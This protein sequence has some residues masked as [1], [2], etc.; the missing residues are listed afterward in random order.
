MDLFI[1]DNLLF[2]DDDI[3]LYEYINYE[4]R[5]YIVRSR[6]DYLKWD[7]CYFKVRF[8]LSEETVLEVLNL[9]QPSISSNSR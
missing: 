9:I 6:I 2:D 1:L 5:T 3:E 8:R 7:D 4:R